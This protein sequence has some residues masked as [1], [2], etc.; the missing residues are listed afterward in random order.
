MISS[1]NLNI[2]RSR[3]SGRS[4]ESF[5]DVPYLISS[6]GSLFVKGIQDNSV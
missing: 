3:L 4:W 1:P 6:M 2:M 5:S